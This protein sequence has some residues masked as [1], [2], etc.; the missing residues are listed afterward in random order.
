VFTINAPNSSKTNKYIQRAT[1]NGKE[2]SRPW[3]THTDLVNGGTLNLNMGELPNKKWGSAE[4]DAPPSS[5]DA[6][7]S[8]TIH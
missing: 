2:W 7:G 5:L 1:L 8:V 4:G 6:T 3:F